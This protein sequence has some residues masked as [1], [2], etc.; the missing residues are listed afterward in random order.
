MP[1]IFSLMLV[2][3]SV[4]AI[5]QILNKEAIQQ[6][7]EATYALTQPTGD[8][9][10]IVT[11]GAV[12]VLKRNE[13]VMNAVSVSN[14]YPNFYHD[15]K[16]GP[17]AL[18]RGLRSMGRWPGMTTAATST[19]TFVR[20]EKM[21]VTKIDVR[22]DGTTFSVFTDAYANVRYKAT[23]KFLFEKGTTPTGEQIEKSV[24]EV[25]KVQ[26]DQPTTSAEP[27]QPGMGRPP[28]P[29]RPMQASGPAPVPAAAPLTPEPAAVIPPP[30]PPP[31]DAVQAPPKTISVGQS[32]D[33]VKAAFGQPKSMVNLGKKQIYVYDS[34]KVTFVDGKVSD[35]Q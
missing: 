30:P 22:D 32:F 19:R 5:A 27:S 25:F 11:A 17:N 9:S 8:L 10:E 6:K 28:R 15:G 18:N 14:W 23:V 13:I 16:L 34:L 7:L 4:P 31:V 29:V 3:A 35:V 20:G 21:W 12:L 2:A 24:A 26:E 33:Q 1:K